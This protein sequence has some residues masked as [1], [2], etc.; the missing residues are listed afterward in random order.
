MERPEPRWL[1]LADARRCRLMR[2]ELTPLGTP[3]ITE[4]DA[5]ENTAPE[6]EHHRPS[7]LHAKSGHAYASF[8]HEEEEE[9]RR[10]AGESVEWLRNR[11]AQ[12]S[13]EQLTLLAPP[14]FLG[15]FRKLPLGSLDGRVDARELDLARYAAGALAS[16]P[17][18]R[19]LLAERRDRH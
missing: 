16:H 15:V 4:H 3:H 13:I 10:F 8:P 7:P 12:E 2:C 14:R 6:R 1:A 17:A 5:L 9:L 11:A 19:A 18:I